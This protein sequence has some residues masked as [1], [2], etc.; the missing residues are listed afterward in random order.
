MLSVFNSKRSKTHKQSRKFST[1]AASIRAR[2]QSPP[3]PASFASPEIVEIN[4][5]GPFGATVPEERGPSTS[6]EQSVTSPQIQL[7]F[8]TGESFTE[9]LPP[10]IMPAPENRTPPKRNVSLPNGGRDLP[11][12]ASSSNTKPRSTPEE[13]IKEE[14]E[15]SKLS[16]HSGSCGR[17]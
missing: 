11:G 1:I 17:L 16:G 6:I 7:D 9:W 3:S 15:V 14:L 13:T 5:K 8:D 12:A 4:E 10:S 2:P